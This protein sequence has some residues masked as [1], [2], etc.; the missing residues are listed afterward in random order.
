[1]NVV[2]GKRRWE[3]EGEHNKVVVGRRKYKEVMGDITHRFHKD[4]KHFI[5]MRVRDYLDLFC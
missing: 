2:K 5:W 3:E 4:C 1:V